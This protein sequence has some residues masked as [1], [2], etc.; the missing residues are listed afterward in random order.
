MDA[1][2]WHQRWQHQQ[3]AFHQQLVNPLLSRYW[4]ALGLQPG[5]PVLVPLCGKSLDMLWLLDQGHPLVGVELSKLAVETFFE[6]NSLQPSAC[7]QGALQGWKVDELTLLCG[8]FFALTPGSEGRAED[9]TESGSEEGFA[10]IY[11]RAAL[12]ALPPSM[13]DAYIDKLVSLLR[14]DGQILLITLEYPPEERQGPPFSIS[15]AEVVARFSERFS[16]EK[17][18]SEVLTRAS[19]DFSRRGLLGSQETVFRLRRIENS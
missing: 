15:E 4:P 2:F 8:D 13:R 5:A 16:I 10:A 3:I 1:N 17:L 11:D 18:D 9:G 19:A 6:E 12:I 14:P 7:Q